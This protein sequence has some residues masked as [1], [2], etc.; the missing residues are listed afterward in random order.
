MRQA[1][2]FSTKDYWPNIDDH[3]NKLQLSWDL[4]LGKKYPHK[5]EKNTDAYHKVSL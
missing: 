4:Y 3:L 1:Q 2:V 5:I